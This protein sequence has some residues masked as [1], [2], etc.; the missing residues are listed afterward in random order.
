MESTSSQL[1]GLIRTLT[2][3]GRLLQKTTTLRKTQNPVWDVSK[4]ILVSDRAST[5]IGVQIIDERGFDSAIGQMS[6]KLQDLLDSLTKEIDW[7]PLNQ[8]RGKVRMTATWKSVM[9]A[10][11]VNGA[12]GYTKPIGVLRLWFK[13]GEDLKNVEALTG[14]K[15]DPYVRVLNGGVVLAKTLVINNKFAFRYVLRAYLTLL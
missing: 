10:G 6:I 15:S 9:M 12:G 2:P 13:R 8:S 4:E 3:V 5:V 7:F 11:A 1:S 14:G